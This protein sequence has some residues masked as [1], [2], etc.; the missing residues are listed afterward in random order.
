MARLY[1]VVIPLLIVAGLVLTWRAWS[2]PVTIRQGAVASST[3]RPT[4]TAP[5][6]PAPPTAT[7]TRTPTRT[8]TSLPDCQVT[9]FQGSVCAWPSSTA[10]LPLP[11][12]QTPQPG[13]VCVRSGP[14]VVTMAGL[15]P[16][17]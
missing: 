2:L 4:A 10:V 1:A 9:L 11:D 5:R 3:A 16:E 13:A 6:T 17:G 8:P 12:C 14:V 15:T 7:A